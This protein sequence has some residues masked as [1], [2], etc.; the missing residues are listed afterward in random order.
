MASVTMKNAVI[1]KVE[2]MLK[3]AEVDYALLTP[4]GEL[5]GTLDVRRAKGGAGGTRQLVNN[6]VEETDYIEKIKKMEI[7]DVLVFD[8][9]D[10]EE[11]S[12]GTNSKR[13]DSFGSSLNA[14]L[15]RAGT[16]DNYVVAR[17]IGHFEILRSA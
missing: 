17:E 10:A 8:I 4:E 14:W 6:W 1:K 9:E 2:A 5:L 7:G 15:R 3:A 11:I 12:P 13:G 16:S